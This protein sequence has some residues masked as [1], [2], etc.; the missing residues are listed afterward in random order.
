MREEA[1]T[2]EALRLEKLCDLVEWAGRVQVQVPLTGRELV[3]V[4][5]VVGRA[6][7]GVVVVLSVV[8]EII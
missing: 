6:D 8:E 3:M 7:R 1:A 4:D 5:K 2:P